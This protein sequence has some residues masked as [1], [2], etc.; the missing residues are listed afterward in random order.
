MKED[1]FSK[2]L[3]YFTHLYVDRFYKIL[4]LRKVFFLY[5]MLL[6]MQRWATFLVSKYYKKFLRAFLLKKDYKH[7]NITPCK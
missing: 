4:I 7:Q 5:L 3:F 6:T 2:F 1:I